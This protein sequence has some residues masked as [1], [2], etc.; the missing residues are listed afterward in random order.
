MRERRYFVNEPGISGMP[1]AVASTIAA[2]APDASGPVSQLEIKASGNGVRPDR[3]QDHVMNHWR[4]EGVIRTHG[5][6]GA[7]MLDKEGI[8]FG[9]PELLEKHPEVMEYVKRT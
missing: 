5:A 3:W 6:Y 7:E 9:Y 4:A 1:A 2:A 8:Y